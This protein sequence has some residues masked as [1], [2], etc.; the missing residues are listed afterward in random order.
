MNNQLEQ[1]SLTARRAVRSKDWATARNC[2]NQILLQ[3]S[4]SAEGFFLIGLVERMSNR[5]VKAREAFERALQL[6]AN[7]YDVAVELANEY[8]IARRNGDAAALLKRYENMLDNSPIYLDRAGTIYT[9]IGLSE[10]A[11]TLYKKAHDLQ[12]Q[13][14]LFAANLAACGVYL[15]KIDEAREIYTWLLDK[16]PNHRRNHYQLARL[17]KAR[18]D[19]HVRQMK[20][21][22]AKTNDPPDKNIFLYFGLAKEHEDLGRWDEAFEYYE[23]AG[24]AVTSVANYDVG[25]DI[26]VIDKVIEVCGVEWLQK[27]KSAV[28]DSD[29]NVPIFVVGLPR[30]GTTLTERIIASHT[31]VQSL[32]ETVFLQM[33]IRRESG[34]ASV[35]NIN[36][37]IV[38]AVSNTDMQ[39]IADGYLDMVDYRLGDEKFFIEKLPF[40]YLFLGFIAKAWPD[41]K[42]VYQLRNPMDACFAM[43][44]QVFTW[45]YKFSYSL[46]NLARYYVAYDRLLRHW[47]EVLG[48]R[49]IEVQY[50]TM[51]ADQEAETRKL[52]DRLGLPFE[53]SCLEFEQN[54]APSTTA[55]S[56]QVR[57]KVHT[58]SVDRWKYFSRQLAPLKEHLERAGIRVER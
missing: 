46:D 22:L 53:Q 12:P 57:G 2:A 24:D 26:A 9:E 19:A 55:S 25:T 27:T 28:A 13:A 40:N 1:L 32:G 14:D 38:E 50:E 30:T 58:G 29:A 54:R 43:Y 48:D 42:I 3:D 4:D 47:R 11:W 16:F 18:D 10:N 51:V 6:D 31:K 17:A 7:R 56:V 41:A 44:K 23:K 8:S 34:I 45:A 21:V 36:P 52:L 33:V 5:P 35:K 20:D 39:N 37:E 49:L 15:G